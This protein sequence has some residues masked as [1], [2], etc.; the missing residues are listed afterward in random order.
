MRH[1]VAQSIGESTGGPRSGSGEAQRDAVR[2][3]R[4]ILQSS[5]TVC[6]DLGEVT[7]FRGY[8]NTQQWQDIVSTMVG[9]GANVKRSRA[10]RDGPQSTKRPAARNGSGHE[11]VRI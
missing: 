11:I 3:G 8:Y 4:T 2:H 1:P 10:S 5:C 6:H 7:K 9:Y